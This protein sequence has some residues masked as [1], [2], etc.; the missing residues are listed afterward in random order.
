MACMVTCRSP[1]REMCTLAVEMHN[2]WKSCMMDSGIP[3][4]EDSREEEHAMM[5]RMLASC[6][7]QSTILSILTHY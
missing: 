5:A 7:V 2:L 4:S 1:H 3:Y 6:H